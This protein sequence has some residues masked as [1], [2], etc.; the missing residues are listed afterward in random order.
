[1]PPPGK[2][3]P[4]GGFLLISYVRTVIL[5]LVLIAVIRL[6]GKRQIGQLEPSE[7]VVAM[8]IADLA[9]IPMQDS[10]IPL[11]SGLVPILTVLGLELVLSMLSMRSL[12]A[13]KL[14]CGKPVILI[15][16]GKILEGNLRKTRVTLD[17][18]T[19]QLRL[20]DILDIDSVQFAILETGG[21]MSVFPYPEKIPATAEDAGIAVA[22]Q[23]LPI[24]VIS[25]GK[26]FKDNLKH[27]GK[28][29]VWLKKQLENQKA[30]IPS[31]LLLTVD[32]SNRIV[33][34][35]KEG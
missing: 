3:F 28:D 27:A 9:S 14:L 1:M 26:L 29:L 33:F 4:R 19:E 35:R 20:K 15:E 6:L 21:Q 18:L 30:T 8:L 17:E 7:L 25:D 12:F 31:T 2:A 10:A 5:Y 11:L 16:N 23:S 22:E 34:R 24:T 32:R 13:R